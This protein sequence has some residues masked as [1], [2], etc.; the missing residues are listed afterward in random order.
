MTPICRVI[1]TAGGD[2]KEIT[3]AGMLTERDTK[4]RGKMKKALKSISIKSKQA[5][6]IV[7]KKTILSLVVFASMF[8]VGAVPNAEAQKCSNA[9]LTGA[10]GFLDSHTGVYPTVKTKIS[11]A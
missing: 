9:T 4:E 7:M 1:R 5:R 8:V 2:P 11:I 6:R 3:S 10:Y